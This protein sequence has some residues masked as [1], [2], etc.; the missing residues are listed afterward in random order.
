MASP[1][2]PDSPKKEKPADSGG[3]F[4]EPQL[5]QPAP[6]KHPQAPQQPDMIEVRSLLLILGAEDNT[7][8]LTLSSYFINFVQIR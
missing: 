2:I 8:P 3:R 6:Q 5:H 1:L 4:G 7:A